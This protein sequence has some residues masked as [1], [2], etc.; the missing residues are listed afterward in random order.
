MEEKIAKL[1]GIED[2][3][4]RKS[5][6][7]AGLGYVSEFQKD[8][9]YTM[10]E[11]AVVGKTYKVPYIINGKYKNMAGPLVETEAV[12]DQGGSSDNRDDNYWKEKDRRMLWLGCLKDAIETAKLLHECGKLK[13]VDLPTIEGITNTFIDGIENGKEHIKFEFEKF[14]VAEEKV[15]GK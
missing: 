15:G 11:N 8:G 13:V 5:F 9:K 10:T 3:G 1:E 4:T 6:K 12:P 7:F 2:K 14:Y